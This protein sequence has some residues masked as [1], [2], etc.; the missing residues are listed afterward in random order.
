MY[1]EECIPE[2]H[3]EVGPVVLGEL[4]FVKAVERALE[5]LLHLARELAELLDS[6]ALAVAEL[7]A[8]KK[9]HNL[10]CAEHALLDGTSDERVTVVDLCKL[11]DEKHRDASEVHLCASIHCKLRHELWVHLADESGDALHTLVVRLVE[12]VGQSAG[13]NSSIK[14]HLRSHLI[15]LLTFV[16]HHCFL[17][18]NHTVVIHSSIPFSSNTYRVMRRYSR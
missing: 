11:H 14:L 1:D 9:F 5:T 7:V 3:L 17:L 16:V 8:H 18:F 15:C 2:L 6:L 12:L 4:V 13:Y 10:V